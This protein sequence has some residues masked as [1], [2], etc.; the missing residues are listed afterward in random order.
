ME[1]NPYGIAITNNGDVWYSESGV[2]PN[3]LVRFDPKSQSF[4]TRA[5][6][7]GGDVV[8]NIVATPDRRLYLA[9]TAE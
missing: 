4:S 5:I 1:S 8:R 3:T 9:C 7:S 6:P 2:K